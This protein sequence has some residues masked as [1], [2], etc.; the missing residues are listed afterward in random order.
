MFRLERTC[1][2]KGKHLLSSNPGSALEGE[3]SK[4]HPLRAGLLSTNKNH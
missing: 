3:A 1:R 2:G 4:G